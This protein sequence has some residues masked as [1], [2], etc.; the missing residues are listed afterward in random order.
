M[1]AKSEIAE[2][3]YYAIKGYL[4][5][6]NH[7]IHDILKNQSQTF[8]IEV[9]QDYE[10]DKIII[11][12]KYKASCTF[13]WAK[14][15]KPIIKLFQEFNI[16]NIKKIIL[17][18]HFNNKKTGTNKLSIE[19]LKEFLGDNTYDTNLVSAFVDLFEIQFSEDL[20]TI[21]EKTLLKLKETFKLQEDSIA[22]LYHARILSQLIHLTIEKQAQ[23]REIDFSTIEN[24][25]SQDTKDVFY[26]FYYKYLG[27]EKYKKFLK[28][29]YFTNSSSNIPKHNRLIVIH[30]NDYSHQTDLI[31]IAEKF[32]NKYFKEYGQ[33]IKSPSPIIVFNTNDENLLANI[34]NQLFT[35][36]TGGCCDGTC[37]KGGAFKEQCFSQHNNK[38][39]KILDPENLSN[40]KETSFQACYEFMLEDSLHDSGLQL[41]ID[42]ETTKYIKIYVPNTEFIKDLI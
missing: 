32:Y 41:P 5:Q 14:V 28:R 40:L 34:K 19:K 3:A 42:Q 17:L 22:C 35:S 23:S 4:Y 24:I 39:I 20:Y 16:D 27:E 31:E 2:G 9:H 10:F 18:C 13:S 37:I 36:I 7:N 1:V 29:Q 8:S 21:E 38:K 11:Q 30:C 33:V 12:V 6:W 25:I 26:S 15:K